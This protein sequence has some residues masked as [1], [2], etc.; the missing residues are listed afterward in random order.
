MIILVV[1]QTTFVGS[2]ETVRGDE[3]RFVLRDDV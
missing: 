1:K 3:E 2:V